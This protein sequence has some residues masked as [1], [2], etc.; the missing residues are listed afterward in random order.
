RLP[1]LPGIRIVV[2]G[3]LVHR[4]FLHL[5]AAKCTGRLKSKRCAGGDAEE[6]GCATR[7]IDKGFDVFN[8]TLNRI[9]LRI[10]TVASPPAI[11]V[12]D[13]EVLPQEWVC[14]QLCG[15]KLQRS[16]FKH[17]ADKDEHRSLP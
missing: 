12:K 4:R 3:C 9:G 17:A 1:R 16:L 14:S 5:A 7:L 8:F 15:L 6:E 10:C 2:V 11:V 13:G